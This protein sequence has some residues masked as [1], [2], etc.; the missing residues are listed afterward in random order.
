MSITDAQALAEFRRTR[1]SAG[2]LAPAVLA[3]RVCLVNTP[4]GSGK[5]YLVDELI[6]YMLLNGPFDLVVCLAGQTACLLE[7]RLV[8]QPQSGVVRLR[9]RPRADCGDLDAEWQLHERL[10]TTTYAKEH[11]C[12]RCSRRPTCFW[13]QQYGTALRGARVIFGTHRHLDLNPRFM[14]HLQ[15]MAGAR[16]LLLLLDEADV[17][18]TPFR[19]TVGNHELERHL[20]AVRG[21]ALPPGIQRRW[22]EQT[23]LLLRARTEDLRERGWSFPHPSAADALAIQ[24]AGL[25]RGAGF[26]WLGYDLHLLGTARRDRRWRDARGNVVWVNTPYLA[27]RTLILAAGMP[28]LYVER[29]LGLHRGELALPL[30][31]VRCQHH[32]TRI[33]NLCSLLGAAARF[34][35]NHPQILDLFAQLLLRNIRADRLTLLIARKRLKDLCADYL[36]RRLASWGQPVTLVLSNGQR[37]GDVRPT[38]VPMIHYGVTGINVFEDFDAAYCLGSYYVDEDV[39]RDAVADVEDDAQR[40]PVSIRLVGQPRRRQAG[41]FDRRFRASEA[42]AV[43]RAYYQQLESNVVLQVVGRVRFAVRPREVICFQCG[44]LTGVELTREFFSLR[45][46]RAY[47]GLPTGSEFDRRRQAAEASRLRGSGLT[48]REIATRLGV[49]ERTVRYRLHHSE[50]DA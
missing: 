25:V 15:S 32:Q 24:E 23:G 42:D 37:P 43:A 35:R 38:V 3:N 4:T 48:T 45:E 33:Y 50:G 21:A 8:Q 39:L 13:P 28:P 30:S 16:H 5:S 12:G 17:L 6:D 1:L 10:G 44:E 41:S 7:R 36:T 31:D 29:Q 49:C 20:A 27:E 22:A 18:T 26:R 46:A 40:F 2:A 47:F 11:V 19:T 14:I 9:P 34:R